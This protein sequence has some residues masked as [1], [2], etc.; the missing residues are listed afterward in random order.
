MQDN[1]ITVRTSLRAQW[2]GVLLFI[3]FTF[4]GLKNYQ[5]DFFYLP[6]ELEEG[7][8]LHLPLFLLFALVSIVKP[9]INIFNSKY[10]ISQHHIRVTTGIFSFK[11]KYMEYAYEDIL[12]V[13][14]EHGLVSRVI[15]VG[16]ILVSSKAGQKIIFIKGVVDPERIAKLIS[17]YIDSNRIESKSK[18]IK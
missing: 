7:V 3:I 12:G 10:E 11:M 18:A 1:K 6:I 9:L 5:N 17:N 2:L 14:V 15:N 8:S 16:D 13:E 4:I